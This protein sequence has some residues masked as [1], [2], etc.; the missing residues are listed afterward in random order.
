MYVADVSE[1]H[2]QRTFAKVDTGVAKVGTNVAYI[3]MVI[4]VCCKSLF[5]MF[6]LFHRYVAS[7]LSGCCIYC[8]GYVAS[9]SFT[10]FICF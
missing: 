6:H 10:Y 5:K 8:N 3:A 4:H 1:V 9:V 2:L 7:A